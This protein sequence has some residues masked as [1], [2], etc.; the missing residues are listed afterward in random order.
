MPVFLTRC[1]PKVVTILQTLQLENIPVATP[2][3]VSIK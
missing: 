1:K 2:V 3:H